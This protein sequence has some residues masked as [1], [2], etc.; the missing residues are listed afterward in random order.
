MTLFLLLAGAASADVVRIDVD[1][2]HDVADGRAY[3]LAGS[4]EA[5]SGM[6][7]FEVDPAN[8]ANRTITDIDLAPRNDRGMVEFDRT[9]SC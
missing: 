7:H 3:G 4:Y 2:R 8:P 6:V 9:S 5:L 1:A